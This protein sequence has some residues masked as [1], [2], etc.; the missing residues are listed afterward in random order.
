MSDGLKNT[1]TS[2]SGGRDDRAAPCNYWNHFLAPRP[3]GM[4]LW[5]CLDNFTALPQYFPGTSSKDYDD[6][7][8]I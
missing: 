6:E 4:C 5:L 1:D 3:V 2:T 7:F 8:S